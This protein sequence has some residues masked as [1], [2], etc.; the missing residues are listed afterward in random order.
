MGTPEYRVMSIQLSFSRRQ[1]MVMAAAAPLL[2]ATALAAGSRIDRIMVQGRPQDTGSIYKVRNIMPA[3][4][5]LGG[6]RKMRCRE[7]F[8]GTPGWNTYVG[9]AR[10]GVKFSFTLAG[11]DI[12]RTIADLKAFLAVSPASIWAI[13]GPNEPDLNPVTY[14]GVTDRR[15][16]YRSG[17]APALMAFLA[18]FV[19]A[20]AAE[21]M[22]RAIPI[23]A[24][25]DYMQA[26]QGPLTLY[27]NTHIYPRPA[28]NVADRIAQFQDRNL[29]GGHTQGVITEWGRTTGGGAGNV[30]SP[31]VS[32]D[33]QA[34]LL[35]S[36][37]STALA[38]AYVHTFSIYELFCWPGDGEMN[39]FGL[40]NVDFS[41]RPAVAAIR[42]V[43]A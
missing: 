17:D 9:L 30:T 29:L 5:R 41:A 39:N 19:A 35:A 31:P 3:L 6:V 23:I 33:L 26:Q 10:E 1:I 18:D 38:T 14:N 34:Q 32:L 21:P 37:I 27:G 40:F 11:R 12:A 16:G 2:S 24:S 25:N 15:L 20:A 36:D 28:T 4:D 22:L 43:I 7:P 13:E 8:S 42:A